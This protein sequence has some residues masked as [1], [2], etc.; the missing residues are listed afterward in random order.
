MSVESKNFPEELNSQLMLS[1]QGWVRL[2]FQRNGSVLEEGHV[3]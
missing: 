1:L 2:K 3:I